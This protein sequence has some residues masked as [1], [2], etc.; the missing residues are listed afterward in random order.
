MGLLH[1]VFSLFIAGSQCRKPSRRNRRSLCTAKVIVPYAARFMLNF[2]ILIAIVTSLV[3]YYCD[4]KCAVRYLCVVFAKSKRKLAEV[5]VW[6]KNHKKCVVYWTVHHFDNWRI[7]SNQMPRITLSYLCQAQHVLSTIMPIIRS[8]QRQR[9]LP[10]RLSCSRVAASWKLSVTAFGSDTHPSCLHLSSNK[11]EFE[12][13]TVYIYIYIYICIYFMLIGPCI[14]LIVEKRQTN[15]MSLA[16]LFQYLL[17]N[18]FRM[19]VHPSSGACDLF[20]ELFHGLC[21]PGWGGVVS[22][23]RLKPA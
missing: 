3:M 12:N 15:L 8:S 18:M 1:V 6:R 19:L 21:C 14:I 10:Y 17:L 2:Q 11:Q 22:L 13:Q 5:V 9:L 16:L 20:V 7:K 4:T 23:C